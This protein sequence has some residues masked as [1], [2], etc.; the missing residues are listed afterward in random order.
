MKRALVKKAMIRRSQISTVNR[1]AVGK[2]RRSQ[3]SKLSRASVGKA[4]SNQPSDHQFSKDLKHQ[5][6]LKVKTPR[7]LK[8]RNSRC[9]R[10]ILGN[11][12]QVQKVI[13]VPLRTVYHHQTK[14][15]KRCW[16]PVKEIARLLLSIQ[17]I[18]AKNLAVN[19]ARATA[20]SY[21]RWIHP[22]KPT[23][24]PHKRVHSLVKNPTKMN[25]GN[26]QRFENNQK[27]LKKQKI[28]KTQTTRNQIKVFKAWLSGLNL[29]ATK[30]VCNLKIDYLLLKFRGL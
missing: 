9:L 21:S 17:I 11:R 3:A 16:N 25:H 24:D 10:I 14:A 8:S 26:S 6:Q 27:Q 12:S 5:S 13:Q 7:S 2:T 23:A 22:P 20:K 29:T 19:L 30:I 4:L 18:A 1:A 15:T 28:Q